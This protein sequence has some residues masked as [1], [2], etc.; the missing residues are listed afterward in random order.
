MNNKIISHFGLAILIAISTSILTLLI[1]KLFPEIGWH[2]LTVAY[3]N[4]LLGQIIYYYS[5]TYTTFP[6][7]VLSFVLNFILWVIEQVFIE[8]TFHD[9]FVYQDERFRVIVVILGAFLWATNKLI[10]DK[11]FALQN[12]SS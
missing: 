4:I 5:T 10:L 9:S 11:V 8:Q 1:I 2:F 12:V 7:T 3:I 6:L